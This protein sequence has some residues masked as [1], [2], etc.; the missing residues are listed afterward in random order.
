MS[1]DKNGDLQLEIS[2]TIYSKKTLTPDWFFMNW[3]QIINPTDSSQLESCSCTIQDTA[4]S[5]QQVVTRDTK[6]VSYYGPLQLDS[7]K[8]SVY[9]LNSDDLATVFPWYVDY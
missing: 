1:Q 8:G 7:A 6:L 3:I 9:G 5:M 4:M 2:L